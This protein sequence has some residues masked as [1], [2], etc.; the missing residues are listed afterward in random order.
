[1]KTKRIF[2]FV[3]AFAVASTAPGWLCADQAEDEAAIRASVAAYV[4]AFNKGDAKAIAAKWSPDAVYTN[5]V[6][7]DQVTG[8]AQIEQELVAIFKDSKDSKVEVDVTSVRFMSP[9]VAVEKGIARVLRAGAEPDETVYSSVYVK[10]G[11]SWLLD[12]MSEEPKAVF[13]SNYQHLKDLQWMIGTWVDQDD[14][15]RIETTSTWTKN[16][17]FI[18]RKFAISVEGQS[19]LSGV[20]VIGWDPV[21]EKIRS[22][23]FDSDGGFGNSTWKKKDN[24]W[25]VNSSAVLSDGRKSSAV[26]VLTIVDDK[27]ITMQATGR[28]L[29]GN[30]LPNIEPI[31]LTRNSDSE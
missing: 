7:G 6:T 26:K 17:N 15:S 9:S 30:I 12:H 11:G 28:T 27:T 18:T 3:I 19:E 14:N 31:K 5:R 1:M 4:V 24:K 8:R 2:R 21:A 22:W 29:D 13:R 20:Q 10:A 23:V 16:Q 25:V